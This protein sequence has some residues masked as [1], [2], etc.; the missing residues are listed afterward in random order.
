MQV[1]FIRQTITCF[2]ATVTLQDISEIAAGLFAVRWDVIRSKSKYKADFV[3]RWERHV[4]ALLHLILLILFSVPFQSA[5][6][7]LR[8][9]KRCGVIR[10]IVG[11]NYPPFVQV[12]PFDFTIGLV[13]N[14]EE[15][16]RADCGVALGGIFSPVPVWKSKIFIVR[17]FLQ[18][19]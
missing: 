17:N 7:D 18:N 19:R 4:A 15:I 14:A 16:L 13:G 8:I 11:A 5:C 3:V 9:T 12:F 6:V 1:I 2:D 10:Q